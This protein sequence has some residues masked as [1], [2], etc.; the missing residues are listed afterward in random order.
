LYK[1]STNIPN[2]SYFYI[3]YRDTRIPYSAPTPHIGD[4][5]D[6]WIKYDYENSL[7]F[8]SALPGGPPG[9]F[10]Q[11]NKGELLKIWEQKMLYPSPP[12]TTDFPNYWGNCLA[13]INDGNN[14]PKLVWGPYPTDI[15]I[16]EYRIYRQYGGWHHFATVNSD[17]YMFVDT[18][19]YINPP[20]GAAG[21]NV[22]YYVKGVYTEGPPN[23]I[24]TNPT[25]TV[26]INISGK[27][28]NKTVKDIELN[29]T[30]N[31]SL[32]Q[33][34]PNPFNPSTIINYSTAENS[35]VSLKIFDVLGTEVAELVN[36][37]K[38]PGNYSVTFDASGVAS[39]L[40]F[41]QLKASGYT[42]TKK[43]LVAK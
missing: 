39:G 3:D 30:A 16:Y 35:F 10:T 18:T 28:I 33:N 40:Y 41:Y 22:Y 43:M 1:I 8:Y 21:A 4:P 26:V 24:E 23:P 29:E 27:Q 20:G 2:S 17:Q 38:A 36:S 5:I 32:F 9:N 12:S 19:V 15:G 34:Y 14:H 25:N 31:F 42:I 6:F 11:V 37:N 7:F 13:V